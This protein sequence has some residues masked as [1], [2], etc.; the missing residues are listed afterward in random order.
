MKNV[1]INVEEALSVWED[2][3]EKVFPT[4]GFKGD[5]IIETPIYIRAALCM[6]EQGCKAYSIYPG[7]PGYK[8]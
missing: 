5:N 3:L 7:I 1:S 2:N 4:R 8:L 6:Q